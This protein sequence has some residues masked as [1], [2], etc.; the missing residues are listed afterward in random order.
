MDNSEDL[1][2]KLKLVES[3][4]AAARKTVDD[5]A[6]LLRKAEKKRKIA[7]AKAHWLREKREVAKAKYKKAK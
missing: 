6:E 1:R 2:S 5:G 4:L 3:K 7:N